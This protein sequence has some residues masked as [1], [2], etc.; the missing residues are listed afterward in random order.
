[1]LNASEKMHIYIFRHTET[2]QNAEICSKEDMDIH[3][4][5]DE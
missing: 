4:S 5:H 2:P 1:M 3:I